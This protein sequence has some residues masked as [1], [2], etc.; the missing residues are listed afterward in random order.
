MLH[1]QIL[2][3]NIYGETIKLHIKSIHLSNWGSGIGE[4]E[5]PDTQDHFGYIIKNHE[6]NTNIYQ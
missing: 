1:Y 5:L 6:M 2:V 3:S 4:F